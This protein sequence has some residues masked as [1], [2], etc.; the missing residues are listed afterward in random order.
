MTAMH[1]IDLITGFLGSG[2]TTFIK[3]YAKFL[4]DHGERVGII[5]NDYGAINVDRTLLREELGEDCGIEMVIGGDTLD[6]HRRRLRTKLISMAMSGYSRIII[7]PSGIFDV[8]EL[9]D[10]IYEEPLDR[11]YEMGS[12]IAV[13]DSTLTGADNELSE[14]SR[15]LICAQ[16]ACAGRIILSKADMADSNTRGTEELIKSCLAEFRC[17]RELN[18]KDYMICNLEDIPEDELEM[19]SKCSFCRNSHIKLPV[20]ESGS[21]GSL[22]AYDLTLKYDE[23]ISKLKG[24]FTD[25]DCGHIFR[26]KGYMNTTDKGWIEINA[27]S[28]EHLN[29]ADTTEA[30]N[31]IILIGEAMDVNAVRKYIPVRSLK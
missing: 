4:M 9:F 18:E 12:V 16:T 27:T 2:K 24:I 1:T 22:F 17:G 15:Y 28:P 7:E 29:T 11:M 3:K 14:E 21:F 25:P 10:L 5:E 31:V 30:E 26:I 23:L 20:V 13:I 19:A 6:T 8:D